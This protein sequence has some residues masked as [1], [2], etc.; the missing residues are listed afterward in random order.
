MGYK[1]MISSLQFIY[2]PLK[3]DKLLTII[4]NYKVNL[5]YETFLS[6]CAQ[7][8]GGSIMHQL[9]VRISSQANPIPFGYI[10]SHTKFQVP[11]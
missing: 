8:L 9:L 10:E 11:S 4:L 2:C 3:L 5:T 1:E 7:G 6:H